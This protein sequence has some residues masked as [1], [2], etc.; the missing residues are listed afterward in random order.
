MCLIPILST[1][2]V[3]FTFIYGGLS[4]SYQSKYNDL[5]AQLGNFQGLTCFGGTVW[6][7]ALKDF[8]DPTNISDYQKAFKLPQYLMVLTIFIILGAIVGACC[9]KRE[10]RNLDFMKRSLSTRRWDDT[11]PRPPPS[12]IPMQSPS[13]AYPP[14]VGEP[15]IRDVDSSNEQPQYQPYGAPAQDPRRPVVPPETDAPSFPP[16]DGPGHF[17]PAAAGYPQAGGAPQ[18]RQ[19]PIYGGAGYAPQSGPPPAQGGMGVLFRPEDH[20][21]R[22]G[23]YAPAQ[24]RA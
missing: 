19:A 6:D 3:I 10:N 16:P 22:T 7:Q 4:L 15:V 2:S 14:A 12:G 1:A 8:T 9:L 11:A 23:H 18:P 24:P 20:P 21:E 17:G 13:A 5:V